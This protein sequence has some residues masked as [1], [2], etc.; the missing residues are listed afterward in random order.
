MSIRASLRATFARARSLS[1]VFVRSKRA[2]ISIIFGLSLIPI[3][4]GA[5]LGLDMARAMIVRSRLTE[6]LDAAGL[7]VGGTAGLS[8]TQMQSMAQQYF[9]ANYTTDQ[10]HFGTPTAVNVL[11]TG[12]TITL[13]ANVPMPTTLMRIAG[14]NTL[15]VHATS[16][17]TYG[18]TKLWVSLVLDNTGSM[19]Q[20][21]S[22]PNASGPCDPA[23]TGSKI[24]ALID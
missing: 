14:M 9:N 18:Q 19:C 7:A 13:S 24:K 1:K 2:N 11:K 8:Q 17:I 5:G 22:S 23:P 6:A 21:D 12:Q 20:T 4:L 16:Q 15:T 3:T 10:S